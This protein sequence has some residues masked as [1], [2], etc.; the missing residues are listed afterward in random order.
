MS[1]DQ[2]ADDIRAVWGRVIEH[3]P[4]LTAIARGMA[5]VDRRIDPDDL[6]Q[7]AIADI[8]EAEPRVYDPVRGSWLQ[9]ART[10]IWKSRTYALRAANREESRGHEP[11]RDR[12]DTGPGLEP[13]VGSGDDGHADRAA[14][15]VELREVLALATDEERDAVLVTLQG[16]DPELAGGRKA[17]RRRL[18]ALAADASW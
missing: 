2:R 16:L 15:V 6:L 8:V 5:R 9:W 11:I 12:D 7:E 17:V 1:K 10:R 14:A 13:A 3:L 18:A 4:Q